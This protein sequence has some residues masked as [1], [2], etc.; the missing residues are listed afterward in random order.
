MNNREMKDFIKKARKITKP[1]GV[2]SELAAAK[3]ALLNLHAE[4]KQ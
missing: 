2:T 4:L 1:F 3:K